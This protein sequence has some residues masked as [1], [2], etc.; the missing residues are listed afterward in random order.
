MHRWLLI[1]LF[2]FGCAGT[3]LTSA[4]VRSTPPVVSPTA[5]AAPNGTSSTPSGRQTTTPQRHAEELALAQVPPAPKECAALREHA[6]DTSVDCGERTTA[7]AALD[8]ALAETDTMARDA[9]LA[10]LTGCAGLQPGLVLALRAEYAMAACRDVLVGDFAEINKSKLAP[11]IYDALT[12]LRLAAQLSR[13]V[14]VPPRAQLPYTKE[15][16]GVFVRDVMATWAAEQA[17]AISALSFKGARLS[18]YGKGLVALE[19]GLADMRFV[20]VFRQVP[21]PDELAS[22]PELA[23]AYYSTL[24]QGLEP[25]KA[26]GRD[27]ALVGLRVFSDVG[28]LKDARV[29]QARSLL[30]HL[31]NGRRI[32]ALDRLVLPPLPKPQLPDA[33]HR[34]AAGLPTFYV[35]FVLGAIEPSA[36]SLLW[37]LLERGLP[38]S[39]QSKLER[40]VLNTDHQLLYTRALFERGRTYWRTSDFA[41][42]V[43]I[44]AN[45]EPTTDGGKLVAALTRALENGPPDAAAMMLGSTQLNQLGDLG[46]LESL[47]KGKGPTAALA[48]YDAAVIKELGSAGESNASF[49]RDLAIRYERAGSLLKDT[50][51][52]KL[53]RDRAA[54]A[55]ETAKKLK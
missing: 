22:D 32:N 1:V 8:A 10:H 54:A 29:D 25:R 38:V 5:P 53:A 7:L 40:S 21:I 36:T 47:A 3:K 39:V 24:D 12:G 49:F 44:V 6:T 11:A 42:A 51:L 27:A 50:A 30:S 46:P 37:A 48:T 43:A 33:E 14:R 28:V 19:A 26:R 20:E 31:Y 45:R 2:I 41:A 52:K 16:I 13:L 4:P 9:G 55:T 35:D 15:R 34:L 17:N 23:D 18:G